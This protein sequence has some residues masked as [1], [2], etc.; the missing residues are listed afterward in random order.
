MQSY[1][2]GVLKQEEHEKQEDDELIHSMINNNKVHLLYDAMPPIKKE[3]EDEIEMEDATD[4]EHIKTVFTLFEYLKKDYLDKMRLDYSEIHETFLQRA[5]PLIDEIEHDKPMLEEIIDTFLSRMV[6]NLITQDKVAFK[7]Q[8][9]MMNALEELYDH[10]DQLPHIVERSSG[11]TKENKKKRKEKIPVLGVKNDFKHYDERNR[12]IAERC[13]AQRNPATDEIDIQ[14]SKTKK[15]GRHQ[16]IRNEFIINSVEAMAGE[17]IEKRLAL[18]HHTAKSATAS[19]SPS[20]PSSPNNHQKASGIDYYP[21]FKETLEIFNRCIP[22]AKNHGFYLHKLIQF[23]RTLD[24]HVW[25]LHGLMALANNMNYCIRAETVKLS[26]DRSERRFYSCFS[27]RELH[28]GETVTCIR[29]VENDAVRLKEWRDNPPSHR[30]PF[31]TPEFTRSVGAFYLEKELCCATTLFFTEFSDTYK[32]QFPDTFDASIKKEKQETTPLASIVKTKRKRKVTVKVEEEEEEQPKQKKVKTEKKH[33]LL[34]NIKCEDSRL[35]ESLRPPSVFRIMIRGLYLSLEERV[36]NGTAV[37][38]CY[39][40]GKEEYR[41]NY[42]TEKTQIT[43]L[44]EKMTKKSFKADMKQLAF[45]T[46]I[47][48]AAFGMV[49]EG[50]AQL[51]L[52]DACIDTMLDFIEALVVP[53]Q[54][55]A[56]FAAA[57]KGRMIRALTSH[58]EE[59]IKNRRG[60]NP[61][62]LPLSC[63]VKEATLK[64]SEMHW[65]MCCPLL[66]VILFAQLAKDDLTGLLKRHETT[67][68]QYDCSSLIESIGFTFI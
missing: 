56:T 10:K 25:P 27:G 20:P 28:D 19:C 54:S 26:F 7:V 63:N 23:I 51:G 34:S 45:Y 47:R 39:D 57:Q 52:V 18:Q 6:L 61:F 49:E 36:S 65:L 48:C 35:F 3:E 44:L 50:A 42:T 55:F 66:F 15:R 64:M 40:E 29:V 68:N 60:V 38:H 46:V 43:A 33:I 5:K 4:L 1:P 37:W 31:E 24:S 17:L 53:E 16:K 32:A 12:E 8:D 58:T 59:R 62:L 13:I 30:K 14:F 22:K 21:I 41:R 67:L 2:N 9:E 11:S